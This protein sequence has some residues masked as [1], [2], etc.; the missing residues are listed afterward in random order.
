MQGQATPVLEV[1]SSGPPR[2]LRC[3]WRYGFTEEAPGVNGGVTLVHLPRWRRAYVDF[4]GFVNSV[5]D[6]SPETLRRRRLAQQSVAPLKSMFA[7]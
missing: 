6:K 1:R 5:I 2:Y 3:G 4:Y 7:P